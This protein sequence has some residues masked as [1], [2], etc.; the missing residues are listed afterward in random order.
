MRIIIEKSYED[1]NKRA[2]KLLAALLN[3]CTVS[4]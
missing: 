2:A 3:I 1:M 4:L